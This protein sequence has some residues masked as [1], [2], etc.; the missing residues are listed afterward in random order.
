MCDKCDQM[1]QSVNEFSESEI[2]EHHVDLITEI[3]FLARE[4]AEKQKRIAF[5]SERADSV[6]LELDLR[7]AKSSGSLN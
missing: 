5:L 2:I 6:E 1:N 7:E 4:I 3:S